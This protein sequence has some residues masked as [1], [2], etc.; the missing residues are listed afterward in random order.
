VL[1]QRTSRKDWFGS[2]SI[3][4]Y[5]LKAEQIAPRA[6]MKMTQQG[7]KTFYTSPTAHIK[8]QTAMFKQDVSGKSQD[9]CTLNPN[10]QRCKGISKKI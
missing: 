4:N 8:K 7:N 1:P 5:V 10:S 3:D 2:H 9:F 6:V